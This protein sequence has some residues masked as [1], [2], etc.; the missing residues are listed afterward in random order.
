MKRADWF[1]L[2]PWI[3]RERGFDLGRLGWS[4]SVF[5][6]SNGHLGLRGN[7]EEGEP[8]AS[9]G[10]FLN[11]VYELRPLP[12]AEGGYGYPE[13][14]QSL[15]NVTNGKVIRLLVDD[16]PFDLRYGE[17]IGHE[18]R[19]DLRS[20]L[21]EREVEWCS[22]AG[23]RL[24]V[25]STRI[26]SLCQR[27]VAAIS[28]E[29]EPIDG[30][31]RVVIQS[32]L[33]ANE[34]E[35]APRAGDPRAAAALRAPL[36]GVF[37][38]GTDLEAVLVHDVARSGLR[39]AVAM[40]HVITAD[41]EVE[42]DSDLEPDL[43]RTTVT[44]VVESGRRLRIV[45]I[46]AYGWSSNRSVPAM[47]AQVEAA[48]SAARA[49]GWDGLLAEQR[50]FLDEYWRIADIE[51]DGDEE[52]QQALRF[53]LFQ[54]L[55]ATTRAERRPIPSKGLTGDGYDGH[56][57]WDTEA[58]VLPVTSLTDPCATAD[59]LRWRHHTMPLA[60]ARAGALG[61][62]G[63]AFPWRTISGEEC[64]GYWPAGTA[65]FH[66]NAA[67]AD[68]V[69][70]YVD[71]TA[72]T[73][74]EADVGVELLVETARLWRSLGHL[75]RE[76]RFHFH[77]VTG[78]DEYSAISDD[79]TYTN[80][81]AQR[82]L[83]GAAD[84]AE[85]YPP[86]AA[87]LGVDAEEIAAWRTCSNVYVPFDHELGVH[88]QAEGFTRHAAW[89]FDRT[90][91]DQYPL[92]RYFPYFELYRRQ[93]TKQA[94]LVLALHLR[95]DAFDPDQKRRD[96]E[97]YEAITV[98]DSSLSAA[99]QAVVAAEVGHLDLAFA[100]LAETCLTDL[101]DLQANTHDGIHLAAA[102]GGWS[103]VVAGFGGLRHDAALLSFAPRLP[104][105]LRRIRFGVY[106]R[107]RQVVV[108]VDDRQATYELAG[109]PP[110][111]LAHHGERF[112]LD[113]RVQRLVPAATPLPPPTQPM[114]RDP[115][116]ETG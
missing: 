3:I 37:R 113:G 102:A 44:A 78:P 51:V 111:E 68:A 70:R 15:I 28:F 42:I 16:E 92:F 69:L 91:E 82:N 87:R 21:V 34:A 80:L 9:P 59:A 35:P 62:E 29:V 115:R 41:G 99:T 5:A 53:G 11:S 47:R 105:Q 97:Y 2:H 19:L 25:R 20:G 1:P 76:G 101:R 63:A 98:R 12:Y 103:A 60:A 22:P 40:D 54:V 27:A 110:L 79:N 65:A 52:I 7:L 67:I 95:G 45:K 38:T 64:S 96:F 84:A 81:M 39:V 13:S 24:L 10:T 88:P 31:T 57:F 32:E 61:L 85:R 75:D 18:R 73:A 71:A 14:G 83:I 107:G 72:D 86:V 109:G 56:A 94:D 26:V 116:R 90:R 4:E 33:V 46:L 106:Y 23:R 43:A 17:I 74:F 8:V 100:Y 66:V 58:F 30:D 108:N 114:G 104:P 6:L 49:T 89:P 48:R 112:V 55:Q 50:R 36:Q 77:G 93:V